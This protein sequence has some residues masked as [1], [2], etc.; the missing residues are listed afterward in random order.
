MINGKR[1]TLCPYGPRHVQTKKETKVEDRWKLDIHENLEKLYRM[2]LRVDS[3][4]ELHGVDDQRSS[5]HHKDDAH[6]LL[7]VNQS[8]NS[9]RF[10]KKLIHASVTSS[11]YFIASSSP[12]S[13]STLRAVVSSS[14]PF[15]YPSSSSTSHRRFHSSSRQFGYHILCESCVSGAFRREHDDRLLADARGYVLK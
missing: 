5:S 7:L 9:F 1:R 8:Y 2:C 14:D 3:S 10:L 11:P 4:S 13:T 15:I 12:L 6:D